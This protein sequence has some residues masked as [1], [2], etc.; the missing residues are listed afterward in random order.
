MV[1][2]DRSGLVYFHIRTKSTVVTC[3]NPVSSRS[4][5]DEEPPQWVADFWVR[6]LQ[7]DHQVLNQCWV[8]LG[9]ASFHPANTLLP[10]QGQPEQSISQGLARAGDM[11]HH[12]TNTSLVDWDVPIVCSSFWGLHSGELT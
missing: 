2:L 1:E 11:K 8:L 4:T 5:L 12:E 10:G 3:L 7:L 6:Q 9:I